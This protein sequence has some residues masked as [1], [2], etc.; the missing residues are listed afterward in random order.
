MENTYTAYTKI[1]ENKTYYFVKKFLT[2][3]EFYGVAPLMESF[4]MHEDFNK[5]CD[6]AAVND[7]IIREQLLSEALGTIQQAKVIDLNALNYAGKTATS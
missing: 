7:P 3:S 4:G 6:I 5:A 1:V 2:F